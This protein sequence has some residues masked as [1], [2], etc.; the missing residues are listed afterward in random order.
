MA[1]AW[2]AW[3]VFKSFSQAVPASAG[4]LIKVE[5]ISSIP[6]GLCMRYAT[7][8]LLRLHAAPL[9]HFSS[10]QTSCQWLPTIKGSTT[11]EE[12]EVTFCN[13]N[14]RGA[15]NSATFVKPNLDQLIER[16]TDGVQEG[17]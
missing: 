6:H 2:A 17:I 7:E 16:L 3:Y 11:I 15:T 14:Y 5:I 12:K 1:E 8:L 13:A 10:E 4:D 9:Q